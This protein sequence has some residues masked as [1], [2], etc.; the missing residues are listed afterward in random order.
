M[1]SSASPH[2]TSDAIAVKASIAHELNSAYTFLLDHIVL[3]VWSLCVISGLLVYLR[4]YKARHPY[5]PL[6]RALW[7]KRASPYSILKL[8]TKHL[9]RS[10][11]REWWILLWVFLAL[12]FLVMKYTIPIVF[13]P[14]IIIDNAAPVAAQAIYVPSYNGLDPVKDATDLLEVFALELPAAFRAVGNIDSV[15]STI[16]PT[17]SITVDQPEILTPNS[18]TQDPNQ[19]INYRYVVTGQDFG[20]QNYPDL[21]LNVEGS[22]VTEYSWYTGTYHTPNDPYYIEDQYLL[23]NNPTLEM[24]VSNTDSPAPVAQFFVDGTKSSGPESNLTWAALISSLNRTSYLGSSDPWYLTLPIVPARPG[25]A[26]FSVKPGRPAL[27]CWQNDIW[28]YQGFNSSVTKLTSTALPGL[29]L[30]LALQNIFAHYLGQPKVSSLGLRLGLSALQSASSAFDGVFNASSSS[31][32]DD[33]QR[34]I[35]AS[36]IATVNTLTETTLYPTNSSVQNDILVSGQI[37]VGVDEFV[38]WSKDVITLSVKALIIIPVLT[39]VLWIIFIAVLLLPLKPIQALKELTAHDAKVHQ[40]SAHEKSTDDGA[41]YDVPAVGKAAHS[42]AIRRSEEKRDDEGEDKEKEG[43]IAKAVMKAI[44]IC[45]SIDGS[46]PPG[47]D[48]NDFV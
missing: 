29:E 27:S 9:W 32:Y 14:Y 8:T 25:A 43:P 18:S 7:A 10:E 23:Y 20:L 11:N 41:A 4:I 21:I 5:D 39:I 44:S 46:G 42:T 40:K 33:L 13:A 48:A 3:L 45:G 24:S 35:F 30:P 19:R 22:C 28:S 12:G 47:D 1:P 16:F 34:L 37:P 31:L 2:G 6:S 38:I 17:S 15:N 26:T 36:Y